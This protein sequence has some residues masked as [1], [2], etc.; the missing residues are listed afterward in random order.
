MDWNHVRLLYL[1]ELRSAFRERSIVVNSVLLPIFMYPVLL[2]LLF[3]GITFVEGL[4]EGF[5]SRVAVAGTPPART[6]LLDTLRTMESVDL[7]EEGADPDRAEEALRA[8]DLDAVME[9]LPPEGDAAALPGN[10]RV[11]VRYDRSVERS[12]RA[13]DRLEGV[14]ERYRNRRMD[15]EGEG[16]G[17]RPSDRVGFRVER[18]DVASEVE[19][20]AFLL[21]QLI[22]LFLVIMVAL[23][24]F[25]PSVDTT[26][27]ERERSTWETTMTIGASRM[28][29]VM[30]KYLYVA[31]L[32]ILAGGL[33]VAA[34]MVSIGS[35]MRPL[36]ER[37]G[38]AFQ[39][40]IPLGA[41]PV[42]FLA[43]V[44]LALLFA[45][46]MMLLAAFA[47]TFKDGQAM[48]TPVYWVI[49][50]PLLMGD[51]ASQHL[52]PTR[53]LIPI[54]NLSM[55]MRD[56]IQGIFLWPYILESLAVTFVLV[57]GV[58]L[59]A[60]WILRFEDFLLGSHDGSFWRFVKDRLGPS[61][62]EG[63]A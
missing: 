45:A 17:L 51:Q 53:A 40:S 54:M 21:G 11:R 32:G 20:G 61:A 59:L 23:G 37:S 10:F 14:L 39:F 7:V 28:S 52:N 24:C 19:R 38:E 16:L 63:V 42:L 33:N 60:R 43:A 18:Q 57:V 29:V 15:A 49:F 27:G 44:V 1:K 22:P 36:L 34:V 5:T 56:A 3:T 58:L 62:R 6:A 47:R 4:A 12:Q 46:A 48:V 25:I 9:F 31:T 55:M 26:A 13:L 2:W 8:G 50:V 41:A 30:A 35:F